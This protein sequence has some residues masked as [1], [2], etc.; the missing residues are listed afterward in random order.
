MAGVR[1][2]AFRWAYGEI[3]DE[4]FVI[5]VSIYVLVGNSLAVILYLG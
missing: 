3:I 5:D 2:I 1:V 4:F